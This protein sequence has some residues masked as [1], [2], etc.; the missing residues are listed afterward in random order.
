MRFGVFIRR[1][2]AALL[3]VCVSITS[4][5]R[6]ATLD[7]DVK[8]VAEA[9]NQF[10]FDLYAR[11]AKD[12]PGNLFF[13]PYSISSALAMTY[14][15]AR[16]QTAEQMRKVLHF[17]L[18]DD[19]LHAAFGEL[20]GQ[21]SKGGKVGDQEFYKLMVSNSV[22]AQSGYDYNQL[23]IHLLVQRYGA[24]FHL[25]DF[26]ATPGQALARINQWSSDKIGGRTPG[27][28]IEI[29]ANTASRL[30]L[31]N[32][33]RLSSAWQLPF[34]KDKT[35]EQTF[36]ADG[37]RPESVPTM[38]QS[39]LDDS[40]S[41]MENGELQLLELS[42]RR[43]Y[44]TAIFLLPRQRDG[45]P[46]LE[47]KIS[48]Q[49]LNDWLAMGHTRQFENINPKIFLP[50]FQ[51]SNTLPLSNSLIAMG[52]SKAFGSGADFSGISSSGELRIGG[53]VNQSTVDLN[54][55]G[56]ESTSVS[57][58][59]LELTFAGQPMTFRADHPFLFLIRDRRS[60]AIL[61][62]GRVSDPS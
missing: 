45:L 30:I 7:D 31:V 14:A 4:A 55:D 12:H 2:V 1:V 52:V 29:S 59:G 33:D 57:E 24:E 60:G 35:V 62:I 21:L 53:F 50:R 16:G 44:L 9:N 6:A 40:I 48:G 56:V 46:L 20:A 11:L 18:P 34:E 10:A 3:V 28:A 51:I 39:R 27:S 47:Q 8:A 15:G 32:A 23:F 61:F 36:Y 17:D 13:S 38:Y 54:E 43:G 25:A 5:A 26:R 22:W 49:K 58:V 37:K 19:R 41:G 42:F